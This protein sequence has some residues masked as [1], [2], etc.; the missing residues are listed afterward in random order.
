MYMFKASLYCDSCGEAI[1]A[2]LD[3]NGE[4][5]KDIDHDYTYDSDDYP[6]YCGN[7]NE[8]DS[9]DHCESNNNCNEA[10]D[11]CDY[12][13]RPDAELKG[14][15][16]RLIGALLTDSF[17]EDCQ[18]WLIKTL[19]RAK[20]PECGKDTTEYQKALYQLWAE[21]FEAYL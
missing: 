14:A 8:S 3:S 11:L 6:K 5:P 15:E 9:I 16:T 1:R 21:E 7:D 10:I 4:K 13:M 17:T 18:N 2:E 20:C 12:G 19:N